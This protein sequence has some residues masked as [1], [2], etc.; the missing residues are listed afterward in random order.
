M[1]GRIFGWF[2]LGI[3]LTGA[4]VALV[5]HALGSGG[6]PEDVARLRVFAAG[7]FAEAWDAPARRDKLA[8]DA[9]RDFELRLVI[10]D[11]AGRELSSVGGVCAG[12]SFRL[13]VARNGET[14]GTVDICPTARHGGSTS[15]SILAAFAAGVVLWGISGLIARRLTRPLD[16]V[17]EVA[18]KLGEGDLAARVPVG[19]RTPPEVRALAD[20]INEMAARIER[21]LKEQR[22]LLAAVSHEM[23]T[24]LT[25]LRVLVELAQDGDIH[26]KALRDMEAEVLEIDA[27]IGELLA[28]A[29]LDFNALQRAQLEAR[30][31]AAEAIHRAGLPSTLLCD[32]SEGA[33]VSAD[34]TLI[35]RALANLLQN[36]IKHGGGPTSVRVKKDGDFLR[37]EVDDAGPGL[38]EAALRRA[39]DPFFRDGNDGA[40]GAQS[41]GLGL[42]LVRR[43]ADAH[44]GVAEAVN[45]DPGARVGFRIP[46]HSS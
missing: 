27:L 30:A 34:P 15:T 45:L 8:A 20:T 33:V 21:Q 46:L 2:G 26:D 1:R 6:W 18:R 17:V 7:Q 10:R 32:A 28:S 3:L 25:R 4:V 24:P 37:F 22:E 12:R 14:L 16:R 5:F 31:L 11:A 42:A 9:S 40:D 13:P 29:R 35:A 43:I 36:A 19:H 41:L 23:R 38:S 39:F 44:G